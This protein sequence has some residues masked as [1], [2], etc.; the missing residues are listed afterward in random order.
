MI[1]DFPLATLRGEADGRRARSVGPEA[2]EPVAFS[3]RK[4]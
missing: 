2:G 3:T 1:P 4:G